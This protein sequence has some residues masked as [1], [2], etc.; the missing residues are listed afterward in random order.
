MQLIARHT[1]WRRRAV[2]AKNNKPLHFLIFGS[3]LDCIV[4]LPFYLL[5]KSNTEIPLA[6][7]ANPGK[8]LTFLCASLLVQK[9][10]SPS[11]PHRSHTQGCLCNPLHYYE[12]R[13]YRLVVT[14]PCLV[15]STALSPLYQNIWN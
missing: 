10:C 13:I 3:A 7:Q 4:S 14:S 5:S 15:L 2:V 11:R 12:K 1:Q 8:N 6:Q 9:H